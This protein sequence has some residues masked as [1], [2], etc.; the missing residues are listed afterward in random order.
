MPLGL[1]CPI[2]AANVCQWE[3]LTHCG[4]EVA[5]DSEL[6]NASS[7]EVMVRFHFNLTPT[8]PFVVLGGFLFWLGRVPRLLM[9]GVW[10]VQHK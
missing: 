9:S 3:L 2:S 5:V 7:Q 8:L 4:Q 10:C 1:V 6:G